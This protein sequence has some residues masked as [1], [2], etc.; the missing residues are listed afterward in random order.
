[1]RLFYCCQNLLLA[2]DQ[3]VQNKLLP[4]KT[5]TDEDEREYLYERSSQYGDENIKIVRIQKSAEPLVS[6]D[7]G[8]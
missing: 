5:T 1:M 4:H 7:A 8:W 6:K 3:S 2:Y